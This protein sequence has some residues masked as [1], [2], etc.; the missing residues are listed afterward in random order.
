M[1]DIELELCRKVQ[2]LTGK[3]NL[4]GVNPYPRIEDLLEILMERG[5]DVEMG[6]R[7]GF[8]T[9]AVWDEEHTPYSFQ[10]DTLLEALLRA[11]IA[12][13]REERGE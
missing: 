1:S 9:V 13:L 7:D 6:S 2:K 5:W 4:P 8:W 11:V 10:Y 12:V 3:D